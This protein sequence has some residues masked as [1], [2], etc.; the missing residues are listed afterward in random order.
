M[1]HLLDYATL[2]QSPEQPK[3]LKIIS[4]SQLETVKEKNNSKLKILGKV[5]DAEHKE[6][7]RKIRNENRRL[8]ENIEKRKQNLRE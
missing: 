4:G 2:L 5:S 8:V 7:L 6:K 3:E 1:D